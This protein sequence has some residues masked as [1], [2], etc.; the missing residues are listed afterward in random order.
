V[1]ERAPRLDGATAALLRERLGEGT[2]ALR[3]AAAVAEQVG[4]ST[5]TGREGERAAA[6]RTLEL[7][8][9]SPG[10]ASGAAALAGRPALLAAFFQNVDL[11]HL[12]ADPRA[13]AVSALV[14]AALER[15]GDEEEG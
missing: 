10:D 5:G 2:P 3:F 12:A 1:P 9:G 14:M 7:L 11:L 13:D 15:L 6:E 8:L 4:R